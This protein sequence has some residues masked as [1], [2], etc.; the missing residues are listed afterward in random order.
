MQPEAHLL[1]GAVVAVTKI[2][3]LF[4][5]L[6]LPFQKAYALG[7]GKAK[8]LFNFYFQDG[9]GGDQ[10]YSH[11]KKEEVDVIEPMLFVDYQINKESSISAHVVFDTWTAASDTEID[12]NTGASGEGIG[13]QS[14][15]GGRFTYK[16]DVTSYAWSTS[17]GVSSEYDYRSLN[18]GGN[19]EGR[20]AE[21]NF[22]LSISPQLFLDQARDFDLQQQVTT[23]YKGRVIS[24]LD[25]SASQLLTPTDV[26]QFGYTFIYMNGMMNNISNTVKVLS[27]PYGNTYS[28]VEERMPSGRKR[29]AASAKL[30]HAFTDEAAAHFSYRFYKDDWKIEADTLEVGWRFS[31]FEDDAFLM[32]TFRYYDQ[33]KGA[34][35]YK[36]TFANIETNMTSDSDLAVYEGHRYGVHYSHVFGDKKLFKQ[37]LYDFGISTGAYVYKRSNNLDYYITQFSV[38]AEF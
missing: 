8:L 6:F 25:I 11:S 16:K 7:K 3:N 4:L 32:P 12:G 37:E 17:L 21:N 9:S 29:H 31:L 33:R 2:L 28:R 13:R 1:L 22:V 24:S 10:I 23:E 26:V 14:R 20:F 30:V 5:I 38:Y 15:T 18:F 27:N 34:S 35:F 19:W 36:Q